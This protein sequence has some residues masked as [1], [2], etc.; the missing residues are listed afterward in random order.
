[1]AILVTGGA[2]YIGGGTV[3][4][5]LAAGEQVVVV[6]DLSYGHRESVP[7]GVPFYQGKAGDAELIKRLVAD[8]GIDGCIH[9]AAYIAVGESVQQPGPYYENNVVQG[10]NLIRAL[11]ESGV[12]RF[13]FSSTC[14]T[15]GEPQ[16]MPMGE[17]HPQNPVNP[18]GFSKLFMEKILE[19]FDTAHGFK[20]VA[21]RYF[22]ASGATDRHG[23]DHQPET[24]LIPNVLHVAIG[25]KESLDVFGGDYP[26]PD[27]TPVRDYIHILDLASAHL[28]AYRHLAAGGSS[29]RLN[30]GTGTGY[31]VKEVIE[32]AEKVTGR[33]ITYN[34][35]PRR[36]GDA[37]HLVAK[38]DKAR[39]V[40][41][42]EPTQSG[43]E[44]ILQSAWKWHLHRFGSPA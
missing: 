42:W 29:E 6:D 34:L 10:L 14:A 28:L 40:L 7:D 13:I 17:D 39:R 19:G 5:L 27:G 43:L 37:S 24:H 38:A 22:N 31:S 23:E 32:T 15:Y 26:T 1:M 35:R 4:Y 3:E 25:R 8:Y 12:K 20:S 41:N 2:G 33:K 36:A 16:H 30:L 21:L 44:N 11:Q 18:Y 9:F